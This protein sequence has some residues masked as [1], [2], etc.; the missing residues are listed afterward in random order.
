MT[1]TVTLPLD[2]AAIDAGYDEGLVRALLC[3][4]FPDIAGLALRRVAG[5]WDNQLWRLGDELA[6]RM[7]RTT[8]A[9][10]LLRKEYRWLPTLA[11]DLPLP[12]SV[13]LRLGE[14]SARFPFAW[15]VAAWV[16]GTPADAAE[17]TRADSAET[18]A[19]FLRALHRPAPADAPLSGRRISAREAT[20]EFPRNFQA[21]VGEPLS[22][23]IREIWM[24]AVAAPAYNGPRVWLH[25]DLHPAN[26][27]TSG[28]ALA[29]VIDFGEMGAGDPAVDLAA[30]WLLLPAGSAPGFFA[31]Y[32]AAGQDAIRR[33]R[34]W[35]LRAALVQLGVGRAGEAG[36]SGGK[37]GWGRA[38]R[39]TLERILVPG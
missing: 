9:P 4:Q 39:K 7:P 38:G 10:E 6:V 34:G 36:A 1:Q 13:P 26:A 5:G 20:Q 2:G 32:G 25:G 17:L 22:A 19:G 31:A 23:D 28:G 21:S 27:V 14:P 11:P 16:P 35:A 8:R 33:A 24:D 37:V 3:D 30:A 12:V 18:L 29:G 15:T